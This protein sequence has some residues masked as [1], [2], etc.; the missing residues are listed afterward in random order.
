M[1]TLLLSKKDVANAICMDDVIVAVEEAY[2]AYQMGKVD[3]PSIQTMNMSES[4]GESDIKSCYNHENGMFSIK[5]VGLFPGNEKGL[6]DYKSS[7]ESNL[8]NMMG[9][10]ILG[11]GQTGSTLSV[12]DASLIT[13]IRTGAA[14]AVSAKYMARK[15]VKAVAVFGAG[16]QGRMQ[17]YALNMVRKPKVVKVYDRFASDEALESYKRDVEE[18]TG[19]KVT[20]CTSVQET[21]RDADI[22]ICTTPSRESYLKREHIKTGAHIIEVG[23]DDAGKS[24][25]DSSL[26]GIVDKIVCDSISQCL[27][28]GE[29]R[30]AVEAGIISEEDVY[31][32]IGE[33][34]LGKK[35]GRD[36]DEEITLFDTTGMGIQ[37]NTTAVVCYKKAIEK[38][39]GTWFEF[40]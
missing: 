12:M 38:G 27:T 33:L 8:P 1:K 34:V 28:R 18:I 3:Q 14:G 36:S 29:T 20:I 25:L 7:E 10:V 31:G 35:S 2:K 39:L 4:Q 19:I 16:A 15:D 5:T 23:V 30:N 26:F 37:D 13:G 21:A 22:L 11:D 17:V 32:E 24:E 40:I 9:N 6:G